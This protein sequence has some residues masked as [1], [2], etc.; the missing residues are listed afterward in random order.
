V[1]V[2]PKVPR[3][4]SIRERRSMLNRLW[5]PWQAAGGGK[6]SPKPIRADRERADAASKA[7]EDRKL[8]RHSHRS[9]IRTLRQ[10]QPG[11]NRPGRA[12]SAL[13]RTAGSDWSYNQLQRDRTTLEARWGTVRT[14]D[15]TKAPT[16]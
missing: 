14:T 16:I 3:S 2:E 11:Q 10:N 5:E 1:I 15:G 6:E 13:L 4:G 9:L 7:R 12:Q 8:A